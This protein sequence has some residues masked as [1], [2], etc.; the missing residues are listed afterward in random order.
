[1]N[2]NVGGSYKPVVARRRSEPVR[3]PET[4]PW[5]IEQR[6]WL[7]F[8]AGGMFMLVYGMLEFM[9]GRPEL[10]TI[11]ND[12][13]YASYWVLFGFFFVFCGMLVRTWGTR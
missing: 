6:H 7:K 2:S 10:S 4:R 5:T 12:P 13:A 9:G 3:K 8:F 11:F 1:M